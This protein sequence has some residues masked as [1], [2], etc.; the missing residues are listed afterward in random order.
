MVAGFGI[1]VWTRTYYS[2]GIETIGTPPP[3]RRTRPGSVERPVNGR[4]YRGTWLLV[5][6]PLLIVAFTVRKPTVLAPSTLPPTFDQRAAAASATALANE[7][8]VRVPGSAGDEAASGWVVQQLEQLGLE[9]SVDAFGATVAGRGRVVLRNVQAVVPG[10]S[11]QTIVVL[12]HRDNMGTTRGANDNASG[13]GALIELARSYATARAGGAGSVTPDHTL[14]FLSTDAGEFGALGARRFALHSPY[15]GRVVAAINLDAIGSERPARVEIGGAASRSPAPALLGTAAARIEEQTGHQPGR[16]SWLGQLIDLGFP[17]S[18]YE[19][20]PLLGRR[21]SA[22]TITTLGDRPPSPRP[23]APDSVDVARLG[24]LGRAAQSLLTS[25]DQGLGLTQQTSSYLYVA[26][27]LVR[28][29]AIELALVAMLVPFLVAAVDLFARCRRWRIPLAPALRSYRSRVLYWLW[30][31]ALFELFALAGAFPGGPPVAINPASSAA[32][33]WPVLTLLGYVV[34]A[35]ASW[36][37]A[38][39]R[40]VRRRPVTPEEQLAGETAALLVLGVVSLLVAATN[41]YALVFVLPSLHAWLWLPQLRGRSGGFRVAV[42]AL[43][44]LGPLLLLGSFAFRYG[45][46]L[47]APWYLAELTAIG[48]V[49]I[50]ALVLFLAWVAAA[51]QLLAVATG[52]Y[53]PY[54]SAAERPPR[55]PL[56]NA[57]RAIVLGVRA[58][59]RQSTHRRRALEA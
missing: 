55:G 49:P 1:A 4:L 42:L 57:V 44:L 16:T 52:H 54:P 6:L 2:R 19:Q 28:G 34:L 47:D 27:R 40:L 20:A 11:P 7:Y 18:L 31:G 33:D 36:L 48:Y 30:A 53:M 59:R 43:G 32:R 23:G 8:P 3:L 45:L 35:V 26:Q 58:R 37:V 41:A 39:D 29:W 5:A 56:R 25:L 51:A 17:Y 9:A 50:V 12:A 22:I 46:G 21:I 38:R 14:L 10:K 13:T 15:A 24:Q